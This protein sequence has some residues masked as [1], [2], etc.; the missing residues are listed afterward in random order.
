MSRGGG[1]GCFAGDVT[2]N[3]FLSLSLRQAMLLSPLF[4]YLPLFMLSFV[5]ALKLLLLTH[6]HVSCWQ[7]RRLTVPISLPKC[8]KGVGDVERHFG[9]KNLHC[10]HY[11]LFHLPKHPNQ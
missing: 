1:G 8:L 2:V 5:I 9:G 4:P 3:F 11:Q 6:V 10:G 7:V